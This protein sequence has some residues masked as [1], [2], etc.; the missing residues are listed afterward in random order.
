MNTRSQTTHK[1]QL[2]KQVW[3]KTSDLSLSLVRLLSLFITAHPR[4]PNVTDVFNL[5]DDGPPTDVARDKDRMIG[6]AV[7]SEYLRDTGRSREKSF[8]VL[9]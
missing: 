2:L 3:S 5:I 1:W 4:K 8:D 6:E 9:R 7:W